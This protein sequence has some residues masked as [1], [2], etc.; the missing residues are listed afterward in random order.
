MYLGNSNP[1]ANSNAVEFLNALQED[2]KL[3]YFEKYGKDSDAEEN[4]DDFYKKFHKVCMFLKYS[5]DQSTILQM[6]LKRHNEEVLV[7]RDRNLISRSTIDERVGR[8]A[9]PYMSAFR[10]SCKFNIKLTYLADAMMKGDSNFTSIQEEDL[11]NDKSD[12]HKNYEFLVLYHNQGTHPSMSEEE[13]LKVRGYLNNEGNDTGKIAQEINNALYS[14][15]THFNEYFKTRGTRVITVRMI[16]RYKL[17][18]TTAIKRYENE[19]A[20]ELARIKDVM[21]IWDSLN[22]LKKNIILPDRTITEDFSST[23]ANRGFKHPNFD[24]TYAADKILEVGKQRIQNGI[25]VTL[26]NF[27]TNIF[28]V[29]DDMGNLKNIKSFKLTKD[30]F[31]A[32][33]NMD[34]EFDREIAV[35]SGGGTMF[36]GV[37][38]FNNAM[39][40][41]AIKTKKEN[42]PV[43]ETVSKTVKKRPRPKSGGNDQL[44]VSSVSAINKD[45]MT[46]VS[47]KIRS[48]PSS[49]Q[50]D[51]YDYEDMRVKTFYDEYDDANRLETIYLIYIIQMSLSPPAPPQAAVV[52][53]L[54]APAPPQAAPTPPAQARPAQ[55]RPAPAPPAPARQHQ[56]HQHRHDQHRHTTSTSTTSTITSS[57]STGTT[58]P[59]PSQA[60]P[61]PSQA[62]PSQTAV[63]PARPAP[64][65]PTPSQAAVAP[66]RPAPAPPQAAPDTQGT[67]RKYEESIEAA[68]APPATPATP[69][70]QPPAPAPNTRPPAT[71][72]TKRKYGGSIQRAGGKKYSVKSNKSK[73]KSRKKMKNKAD[74]STI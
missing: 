14:L 65:P 33:L 23:L 9:C 72:R 6:G 68:P 64:A 27:K 32:A 58:A 31:K 43:N 49:V 5:G 37:N 28:D 30:L 22:S 3:F 47:S 2:Y 60:P 13:H 70:R 29:I 36:R 4:A 20:F 35:Q 63:A 56:H 34:R 21:C 17:N 12:I 67:K 16:N 61:A 18:D 41:R 66:A 57:S 42:K 55:A 73:Q 46:Y 24:F 50:V 15:T 38:R 45:F 51:L 39:K 74:Q 48:K 53:A 7:S 26:D 19:T 44:P 25:S 69:A 71:Q 62:A 11:K 1:N 54:P 10:M 8:Y 59:A 52:P 40:V